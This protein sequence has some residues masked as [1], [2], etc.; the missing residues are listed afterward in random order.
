LSSQPIYVVDASTWM[1]MNRQMPQ[2]VVPGIWD[3]VDELARAGRCFSPAEVRT[4]LLRGED[5][6]VPWAKARDF[7]FRDSSE[8]VQRA[9]TKVLSTCRDL[10]NTN[11]AKGTAD[12]FVV[13]A[14]FEIGGVVV[15]DESRKGD[16]CRR[17]PDACD[18]QKVRCLFRL[19]WFRE[20]GVK[21]YIP[22]SS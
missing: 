13:A 10:V 22:T 19:D 3:L 12:P 4:E 15:S 1:N 7:L 17:I 18:Q 9:V 5:Q 16:P 8:A 20:L 11:A 14:A 2:D 6:L 21:L